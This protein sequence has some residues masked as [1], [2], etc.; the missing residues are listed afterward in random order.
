MTLNVEE[1]I[2][3]KQMNHSAR[4]AAVKELIKLMDQTADADL[5]KLC[6]RLSDKLSAMSDQKFA[7]VDFTVYE[8]N[9][10]EEYA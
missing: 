10:N 3:M 2:L 4:K 5:K 6:K 1:M 9:A 8:E 7:A